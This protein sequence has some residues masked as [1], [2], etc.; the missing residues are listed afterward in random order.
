MNDSSA[1]WYFFL[2]RLDYHALP[3]YSRVATVAASLVLLLAVAVVVL[4]TVKRLWPYLWKEWFTSLDH[5]RIGIMYVVLAL[6]MMMRG[7]IEAVMI[8]TQQ[9]LAINAPGYLEPDHFSQ[10]F[11]T[12]GTIMIF[13]MAMPFLTGLI[14]F[15]MPLQIGARDVR[16]PLLNAISLWLTVAGALL[17]MASLML[18]KFST[19]GWSGYPPFTEVDYQ[20]GVGPDYWIWALTLSSIGSTLTGLNF[21]VTI[22][23]SRCCGMTWFRLPL[24]TWTALCT[25]VLMIFAMPPLTV[26]TL[27][28]ALDRYLD[29]HFF[30]NGHGGNLMNF[31]NLFWLFGHPEVYIL[32]L[33]AFG[34]FSEVFATFSGK[35][36]YGYKSLVWASIAITVLSFT[37]WL[38]HFFTMGQSADVNAAFGIATMLIGIPTGV[39]IYDWMLTMYRGRVR[40]SVP[41]L[42]CVMFLMLF[43]IGG[44][45]GITL[46]APPVDYQV[47]NTVYLV[48][49][50]HNMLIPGTLFGLLAGYTYWFPKAFGFRLDERWGRVTALS[51]GLGFL[52]AFMPLY[53]LGVSGM[54]RRSQATFNPEFAPSLWVAELGAVVLSVA[55]ISLY[56]QLYVSIRD[57]RRNAVPVGDPWD[58]R[59]LEWA[60]PA[61][62][63]DYNFALAPLVHDRDPFTWLKEHGL[64]YA[65]VLRFEDILLPKNSA[66]PVIIG[67]A[68]FL[69]AFGLVW[70]IGWAAVGGI[71]VAWMAVIVRSFVRDTERIIPAAQVRQ[72]HQAWL[73]QARTTTAVSR[74]DED[75]ALNAGLARVTQ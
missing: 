33:P 69:C 17:V 72:A 51:F 68:S 37:V 58:G 36:L 44:L 73:E 54:P 10:M 15:A 59:T 62:P 28:L 66:T 38:H 25:S 21:A 29:F 12:H 49:H 16:F 9:A 14:N 23:K 47:H 27:L 1:L 18:G 67:G 55:L 74:D 52:L 75:D 42:Y 57:R 2:G 65:P 41:I 26:A 50:F 60:T 34:V 35:R 8:R 32:I 63:P 61:P 64:A 19:G 24:F 40:L 20:P 70:H 31:V 5:K 30:S 4:I 11:S 53:L 45:T 56:I 39:K 48:A 3:L 22:Y 7:I 71:V 13:F 6:I 43:V 46:A